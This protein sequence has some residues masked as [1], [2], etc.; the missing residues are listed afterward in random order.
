MKKIYDLWIYGL[1]ALGFGLI[2]TM[3]N[4]YSSHLLFFGLQAGVA[5]LALSLITFIM[6]FIG[7]EKARRWCYYIH[8]GFLFGIGLLGL[9][10][11]IHG[12]VNLLWLFCLSQYSQIILSVRRGDVIE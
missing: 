9:V 4:E 12:N 7:S 10:S 1:S 2:C 8:S 3:F 11:M 6:I 5:A